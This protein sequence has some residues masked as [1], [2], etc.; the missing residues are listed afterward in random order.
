M[1]GERPGQICDEINQLNGALVDYKWMQ[2]DLMVEVK[3]YG[4]ASGRSWGRE[5]SK[6]VEHD[7]NIDALRLMPFHAYELRGTLL[8]KLMFVG[9]AWSER[10]RDSAVTKVA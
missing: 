10:G 1:Y 4:E 7:V 3:T 8:G 5:P 9:I 6:A 2:W